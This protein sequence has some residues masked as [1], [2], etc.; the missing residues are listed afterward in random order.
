MLTFDNRRQWTR[1]VLRMPCKEL[2]SAHKTVLLALEGYADYRDGTGAHPG[3]QNLSEAAGVDVRTVRRALAAG[4]SLGLIQQTAAAN[5]KAGKAAEYS[6]TLPAAG[7]GSTGHP[8]PVNGSTT[9]HASPVNNCTTGHTSP[10]ETGHHRTEMSFQPDTP[11]LPPKPYTNTQGELRNS[12]TSPA[13]AELAAPQPPSRYCQ[14][15]PH[16]TDEN[17]WRCREAGRE[18][19]AWQA[20]QAAIDVAVEQ[21]TRRQRQDL[22]VN[23][24]DCG[25]SNWITDDNGEPIRKCDHQPPPLPPLPDTRNDVRAAQ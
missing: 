22:R 2:S 9:G 16:G 1:L 18:F 3:E 19:R 13:P 11:V 4:R 14:R 12:G 5:P 23:C 10:V 21:N 25:G 6:L 7:G 8:S 24:P 20:A 17:C 15:H